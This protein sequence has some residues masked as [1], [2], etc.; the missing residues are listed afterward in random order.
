ME[1][2]ITGD[3]ALIKAW[4]ADKEKFCTVDYSL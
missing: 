4:K 2:A 3:F 1:E